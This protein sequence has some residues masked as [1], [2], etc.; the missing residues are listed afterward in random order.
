M[1]TNLLTLPQLLLSATALL[2][3]LGATSRLVLRQDRA[4]RQILLRIEEIATPYARAHPLQ[5]L[6]R[7]R[8]GPGATARLRSA[9][10]KL[11]G[12]DAT[13]A[14]HYAMRAPIVLGAALVGAVAVSEV[15]ASLAGPAARLA[16]P[17]AWVFGSR[18]IFAW[19]LQ[20][21]AARLYKQFP[22]ALALIV[23]SV[24][25]GIPVSEAVRNL[26]KEALEP[27][28][29]EFMLLSD[30]LAIGVALDQALRDIAARN[31][32][33]EYR[34]FATALTLQA[35]T[36]GGLSETL[37]NLAEVI[38]KRVAVRKRAHAL[39]S[40]TRTSTY[41]L[42]A[43]PGFTEGALGLI[44]PAYISLLFTDPIGNTVL[45]AAVGML[46]TGMFVMR[47]TISRSLR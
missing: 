1:N 11:F 12:Y 27:T 38:R 42:A 19:F 21:R 10:S 4:Q 33:P 14:S 5:Q 6:D 25:V 13:R 36:G 32:L 20:R 9:T 22:D 23:R 41:V 17:V 15:A 46:A 45:A 8:M 47:T 30:Q 43:L 34:F 39:A 18:R 31:G 26:S 40:E 35:Q 44:N 16:M 37:E 3:L 7:R 2:I 29:T 24:S 28:A